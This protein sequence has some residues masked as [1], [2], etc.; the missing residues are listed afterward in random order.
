MTNKLNVGS[1][2]QSISHSSNQCSH[3]INKVVKDSFSTYELI[4]RKLR[5]CSH[6]L[7][8]LLRKAAPLMQCNINYFKRK[9]S[10]PK[11]YQG[12]FYTMLHYAYC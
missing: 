3:S 10:S 9:T 2:N 1:L 5:I 12:I 4:H 8:N 7:K 6:L 11:K